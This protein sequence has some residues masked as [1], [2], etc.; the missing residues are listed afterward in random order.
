[1]ASENSRTDRVVKEPG[2]SKCRR[3]AR[4]LSAIKA[5]MFTF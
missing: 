3:Y 4:Q 5:L 1:L 2:S